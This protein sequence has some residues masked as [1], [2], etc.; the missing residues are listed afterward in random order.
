[1]VEKG[2]FRDFFTGAQSLVDQ[3]RSQLAAAGG[4]KVRWHVAEAET[5]KAIRKLFTQKSVSGIE[6]VHT[7]PLP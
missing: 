6:V 1:F 5:A 3:A 7:P 2:G 4:L